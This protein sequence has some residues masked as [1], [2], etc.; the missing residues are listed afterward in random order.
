[1]KHTLWQIA[2]S[3]ALVDMERYQELL[4]KNAAGTLTDAGRHELTQRRTE[5]DRF[6]LRK[7][8]AAALLRWRGHKPPPA[9]KL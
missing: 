5:A 7:G 2:R 1:M 3:R 8:Y 4:D 6:M 9:D